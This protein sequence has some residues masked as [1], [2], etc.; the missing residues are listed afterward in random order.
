MVSRFMTRS[1][2]AV[3]LWGT[4]AGTG[5]CADEPTPGRLATGVRVT[6]PTRLDWVFALANQSPEKPPKEWLKGYDS[7]EQTY[8]LFVPEHQGAAGA[9]PTMPL[10]LFIS[11]GNNAAGWGNWEA[12]CRQHGILFA[13]PR[14][15]GNNT[16]M[17]RRVRIILDVLD[18]VGRR[19]RVDPDRTYVAG[20]SGGARVA[21]AIAFA[22]PEYFGGIAAVCGGNDLREEVWLRQRVADRLSVALVTGEQDF[23]R[24]EAERFRGP[25]LNA[26]GV[27]TKVWVVPGMGHSIPDEA[28]FGGVFD[29]L[30]Q[31]VKA[32]RMLAEKYPA[33]RGA[34]EKPLSREEWANALYEESTQR[35]EKPETL[36]SGLMQLK[37][38]SV[39][40]EGLTAADKAKKLLQEYD[41]RTERPWEKEDL[42]EQ[43]RHLI[44][45]ARGVDAYASGDLPDQY[46]RQR[47]AMIAA[48]IQLW[49]VIV[50]DGQDMEAAAEGK[51]RIPELRKLLEGK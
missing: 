19:F 33:S 43:R 18:D 16:P 42:A 37:G 49:Q 4:L 39:R 45:R 1:G 11:A 26:V 38:L 34:G 50:Q 28:V 3:L 46:L 32:R 36:Y 29:W 41:S 35:L 5:I 10:V 44:A 15:A 8:D 23:N 40:W 7:T 22:L 47:P 12:V 27:R 51:R 25:M 48:A 2:L 24:G 14:D 17:P 30:E 13:A 9:D 6:G 21:S 20:Y 31:Q